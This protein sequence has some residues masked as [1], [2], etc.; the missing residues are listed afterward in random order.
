MFSGSTADEMTIGRGHKTRHKTKTFEMDSCGLKGV[1]KKMLHIK[2]T[3]K[4]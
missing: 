2:N 1:N 3:R 4:C